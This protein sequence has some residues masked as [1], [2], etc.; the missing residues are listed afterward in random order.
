MRVC[1]ISLKIKDGATTEGEDRSNSNSP[2]KQKREMYGL[3]SEVLTVTTKEVQNIDTESLGAHACLASKGTDKIIVEFDKTGTVT[4]SNGYSFGKVA[5]EVKLQQQAAHQSPDDSNSNIRIG[6]TNKQGKAM[7]VSGVMINYGLNA[8]S[9]TLKMLLDYEKKVLYVHSSV[10]GN[11]EVINNI[12]EGTLFPAFQNKTSRGAIGAPLKLLVNFE[13]STE[14]V[15]KV[16]K[17]I[18]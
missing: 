2:S 5:W 9:P 4:A 6:V 17:N 12:P 3:W 16:F 1:P 8:Q 10:T 7:S 18:E 15:Q 14:V 13:L 11:I